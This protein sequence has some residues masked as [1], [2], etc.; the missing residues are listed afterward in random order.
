MIQKAKTE[1]QLQ[2]YQLQLNTKQQEIEALKQQVVAKQAREAAQL[3]AATTPKVPFT[4]VAQASGGDAKSFIYNKESGNNPNS[5]NRSS[6]ACGLGQALPCSK[7]GCALGDYACQDAFFTR[8][9]QQRY[10]SWE[11]AKAFWLAHHWW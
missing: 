3:A 5:I 1:K 2:E 9:M 4:P 10:G 6:G 11:N 8:Y 7:M